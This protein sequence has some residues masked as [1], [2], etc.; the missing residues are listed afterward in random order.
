MWIRV[1]E[2]HGVN[3]SIGVCWFC[4]KDDGTVVLTGQ[5]RNDAEAP[6]RAVW[7]KDPCPECKKMMTEGVM[8][9]EVRDGSDGQPERTG[10]RW[11]VIDEAIKRAFTEPHAS[12]VLRRRFAFIE[13]GGAVALGLYDTGK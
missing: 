6:R 12:E 10:N 13:F 2:K 5:L 3:P 4:G 8:L 1:S 9:L 11:V 7:S